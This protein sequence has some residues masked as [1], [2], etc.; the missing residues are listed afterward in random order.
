MTM[1]EIFDIAGYVRI[2][3]DDDLDRDIIFIENQKAII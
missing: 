3:V 1:T 2:S